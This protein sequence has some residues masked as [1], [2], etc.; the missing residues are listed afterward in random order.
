MPSVQA[1]YKHTVYNYRN[2]HWKF[3]I[4]LFFRKALYVQPMTV[5][6]NE[7]YC[8]Y[9]A[10]D[11][12]KHTQEEWMLKSLSFGSN[13]CFGCVRHFNVLYP[14][15]GK[16]FIWSL[17]VVYASTLQRFSIAMSIMMYTFVFKGWNLLSFTILCM[18][19][20]LYVTGSIHPHK[21]KLIHVHS[22]WNWTQSLVWLWNV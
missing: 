16:L 13:L 12:D 9:Y 19:E 8:L 4:M 5:S 17:L 21:G 18:D 7:D 10:Y 6:Y 2:L 22:H 14:K 20:G 1:P 3:Q 15:L 11:N